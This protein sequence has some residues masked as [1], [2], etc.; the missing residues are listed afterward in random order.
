MKDFTLIF[1]SFNFSFIK[2]LLLFVLA[3][4][5]RP[6]LSPLICRAVVLADA[7][8]SHHIASKPKSNIINT[9]AFSPRVA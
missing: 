8:I 2:Q 7:L 1:N 4:N 3:N 5:R 6:F 9:E